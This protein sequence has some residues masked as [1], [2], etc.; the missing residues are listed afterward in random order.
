MQP[1]FALLAAKT[2]QS[3]PGFLKDPLYAAITAGF[4][5]LGG[6][7]CFTKFEQPIPGLILLAGA[8]YLGY[9]VFTA[10]G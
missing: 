3:M 8:G 6:V 2:L 9:A 10:V 4:L 7:A 5:L 1:E